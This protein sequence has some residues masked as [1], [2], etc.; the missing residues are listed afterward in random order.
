ML[1]AVTRVVQAS[2]NFRCQECSVDKT[3]DDGDADGN[4]WF[5]NEVKTV[6]SN[7]V[8]INCH[9]A[10]H[11][12]KFGRKKKTTTTETFS[13]P[14]SSMQHKQKNEEEQHQQQKHQYCHH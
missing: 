11:K 2:T 8:A 6:N 12:S 1:D 4:L 9:A 10:Y 14:V 5:C 3:C 13:S 7:R